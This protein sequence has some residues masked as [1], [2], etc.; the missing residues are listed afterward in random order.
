MSR[1]TGSQGRQGSG[2]AQGQAGDQEGRGC[3]TKTETLHSHRGPWTGK[4]HMEDQNLPLRPWSQRVV[5]EGIGKLPSVFGTLSMAFLCEKF[6][7]QLEE[8]RVATKPVTISHLRT[9]CWRNLQIPSRRHSRIHPTFVTLAKKRRQE[10]SPQCP[11]S[12]GMENSSLRA[13]QSLFR[14]H[15]HFLSIKK[16]GEERKKC[17]PKEALPPGCVSWASLI[18]PPSP[19]CM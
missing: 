14:S 3:F 2:R 6:P 10:P 11:Q 17:K 8:K 12:L 19:Q 9:L 18:P 4:I 16:L 5:Q 13:T 7:A 15:Q 1:A